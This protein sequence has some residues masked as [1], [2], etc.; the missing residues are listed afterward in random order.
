RRN[1]ILVL[2]KLA[3][4]AGTADNNARISIS[5]DE[6]ADYITNLKTYAVGLDREL[7][8]FIPVLSEL[9]LNIISDE[10]AGVDISARYTIWRC[11]L[12]NLLRARWGLE[13]PPEREDTIKRVKAGIL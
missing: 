10:A 9:S 12:S 8:M 3:A 2:T 7:S 1:E 5:R 11:R 13:L 6:D 4:T